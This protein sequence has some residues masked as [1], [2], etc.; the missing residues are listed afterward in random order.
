[1]NSKSFRGTGFLAK[2]V[3]VILPTMLCPVDSM[4]ETVFKDSEDELLKRDIEI[5][6]LDGGHSIEIRFGLNK[7]NMS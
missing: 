3:R 2:L 7:I 4:P 1:M 6:A 5:P